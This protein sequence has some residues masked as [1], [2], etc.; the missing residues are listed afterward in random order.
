MKITRQTVCTCSCNLPTKLSRL[1]YLLSTT[2]HHQG[3]DD[4]AGGRGGSHHT[5][6]CTAV[7]NYETNLHAAKAP[8]R[9]AQLPTATSGS[10]VH[11]VL[12]Q[13]LFDPYHPKGYKVVHNL[14]APCITPSCCRRFGVGTTTRR[15]RRLMTVCFAPEATTHGGS[16]CVLRR[17]A[18]HE[19]W[20][21][22]RECMRLPCMKQSACS[23]RREVSNERFR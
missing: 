5:N 9:M 10:E 22:G 14:Y 19:E 16:P 8:M 7:G 23:N 6:P 12:L 2:I 17:S 18:H 4:S 20:R 21:C 3:S 11:V 13:G 15:I 1:P